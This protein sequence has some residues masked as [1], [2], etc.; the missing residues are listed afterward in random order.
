MLPEPRQ[1]IDP[2]A[3]NSTLP[4]SST[5]RELSGFETVEAI[6]RRKPLPTCSR[7]RTVSH[8]ITSKAC[9]Q[10]HADLLQRASALEPTSQETT[11]TLP[12]IQVITERHTTTTYTT[13]DHTTTAYVTAGSPNITFVKSIFNFPKLLGPTGNLP[14]MYQ[15]KR[16]LVLSSTT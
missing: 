11:A 2:I 5:R 1:R 12:S 9:P 13:A 15:S 6:A 16:H 8:I 3:A 4:Q 14:E 7:C 10:R